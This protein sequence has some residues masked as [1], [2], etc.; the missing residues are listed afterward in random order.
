MTTMFDRAKYFSLQKTVPMSG[1][2]LRILRAPLDLD[3]MINSVVESMVP[4]AKERRQTLKFGS[5][6]KGV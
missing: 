4:T 2:S 3:E 5:N 1:D 6:T